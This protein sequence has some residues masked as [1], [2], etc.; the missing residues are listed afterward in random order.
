MKQ[1]TAVNY[2]VKELS[3][4]FGKLQTT[5]MQ[6]LLI[7]DA[8]NKAKELEKKQIENAYNSGFAQQ[9]WSISTEAAEQYFTETFEQ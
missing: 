9:G 3:D 7:V 4:I 6:D 5:P 8:I 2:L 1:K